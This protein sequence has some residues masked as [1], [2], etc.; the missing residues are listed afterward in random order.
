M[1]NRKPLFLL[2]VFTCLLAAAAIPVGQAAAT[3]STATTLAVQDPQAIAVLQHAVSA[4][5]G[6]IA[7]GLVLDSVT[8]GTLTRPAGIIGAAGDFTWE[9]SGDEFRYEHAGSPVLVSGHGRPALVSSGKAANLLGHVIVANFTMHLPAM[10]L[11]KRLQDPSYSMIVLADGEVNG[12]PVARVRLKSESDALTRELTSQLWFF[13]KISGLPLRVEYRLADVHNASKQSIGAVEFSGFRAV[14]GVLVPF[15]ITRYVDGRQMASITL[16]S[17]AFNQGVAATD[18][19][20][21]TR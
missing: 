3:P 13:D 20:G 6:Q 18:F 19:D 2:I 7:I 8:K 9:T 10:V 16:T 5:G 21:G 1:T 17:V 11:W 14:S 12:R 15:G 4:L